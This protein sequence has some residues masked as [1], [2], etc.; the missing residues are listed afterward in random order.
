MYV[1]L[2]KFIDA[3]IIIVS[4]IPL[5]INTINLLVKNKYTIN[6]F[7]NM[8]NEQYINTFIYKR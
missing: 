6:L 2:Y 7:W 5:L 8:K 3:F 4:N 1:R